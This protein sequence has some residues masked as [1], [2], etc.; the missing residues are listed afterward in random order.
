ME[1]MCSSTNLNFRVE[2]RNDL[3]K[4]SA[5]FVSSKGGRPVKSGEL[6]F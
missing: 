4:T 6:A 1:V 3:G 5:A 2:N